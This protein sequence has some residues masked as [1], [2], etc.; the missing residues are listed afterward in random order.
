MDDA[1]SSIALGD[2]GWRM[3]QFHSNFF[4]IVWPVSA[5]RPSSVTTRLI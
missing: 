4:L 2:V 5:V 3:C 1:G